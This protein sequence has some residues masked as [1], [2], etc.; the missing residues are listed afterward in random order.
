MNASDGHCFESTKTY[1]HNVGLSCAFRQ[2]RAKSHCRFIHGYALKVK[3]V[4]GCSGLDVHNWV[5]DFGGL[6]PLKEWLEEHYDHKLLIANDDPERSTFMALRNVKVADVEF[7]D[8][9]GIE[10]FA[11][12]I[13]DYCSAALRV[14]GDDRVWVESVEVAEHEANSAIYRRKG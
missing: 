3:I 6:K 4:F 1:S 5:Q 8:H 10:A 13:F 7:R 2:W 9:I 12:H 14:G 11:K